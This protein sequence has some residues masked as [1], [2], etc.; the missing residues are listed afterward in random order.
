[1]LND[2]QHKFQILNRMEY[3]WA[4]LS[5]AVLG[6][7]A[8]G[9]FYSVQAAIL[10]LVVLITLNYTGI[11]ATGGTTSKGVEPVLLQKAPQIGTTDESQ[12][13][14][15]GNAQT[16]QLF[17]YMIPG[18]RTGKATVCDTK[19]GGDPSCSTDRYGLCVCDKNDCTKCMHLAYANL[20]NIGNVVKVEVLSSPDAGRP[21]AASAQL[22]LR[23]TGIGPGQ[24]QPQVNMETF[25]LPPI[26]FQK[27]VLLTVSREGRRFD[28][29]YNDALVFSKRAQYSL[30]TSAGASPIVV[31]QSD[32]TGVAVLPSLTE[33]RMSADDV[34]KSFQ[35]KANT[36]GEPI[37]PMTMDIFKKLHPCP[38]GP[39]FKAPTVRPASPLYDWDSQYE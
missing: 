18:Q 33:G 3:S 24:T 8:L 14:L 28:I 31:G 16:Y 29:Y 15:R 35:T 11:F 32:F 30:D 25:A 38:D 12:K 7:L 26:P 37:I 36:N 10:V 9:Y 20:V 6:V 22:T 4:Y 5:I 2:V 19:P 21:N 39:C 13:Y 23:T 17:V 27:W 34:T 1:M